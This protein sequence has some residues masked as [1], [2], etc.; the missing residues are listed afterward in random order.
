MGCELLREGF[1]GGLD[2]TSE[3]FGIADGDL[4]E[5]LAVDGDIGLLQT[6]H[7]FGV[8]DIVDA[9]SGIDSA[10]P[11]LAIVALDEATGVVGV[12]E[13]VADLLFRGFEKEVLGAEISFGSL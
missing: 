2:Q 13:R 5:H 4:G 9:A 6:I 8:G 10:D 3:A 12:T 1:F 11:K 7:E